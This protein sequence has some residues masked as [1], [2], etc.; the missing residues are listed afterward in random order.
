MK[1]TCDVMM[2]SAYRIR[3][4]RSLKDKK[5]WRLRKIAKDRKRHKQLRKHEVVTAKDTLH[6]ND[7]HILEQVK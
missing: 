6:N 2:T 4:I 5:V 7:P 3:G 1:L